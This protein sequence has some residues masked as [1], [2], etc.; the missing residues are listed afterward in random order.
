MASNF[1]GTSSQYQWS[2]SLSNGNNN[3]ANMLAEVMSAN[4]A[5]NDAI[6]VDEANAYSSCNKLS[7]TTMIMNNLSSPRAMI[8]QEM[9]EHLDEVGSG[10][11]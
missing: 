8:K 6:F 9:S 11:F 7:T 10:L 2:A 1:L 4:V 5:P 3:N